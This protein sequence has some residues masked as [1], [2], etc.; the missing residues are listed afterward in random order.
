MEEDEIDLEEPARLKQ[1]GWELEGLI[2][3][4]CEQYDVDDELMTTRGRENTLSIAR[5][6]ICHMEMGRFGVSST[7]LSC[8]LAMSQ[9]AISK[10]AK[11]GREYSRT[12][13][14]EFEFN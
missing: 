13:E 7:V 9:S 6:L 5:A 2:Q 1:A 11:R 3:Y 8:R 14:I 12:E 4:L 10:A